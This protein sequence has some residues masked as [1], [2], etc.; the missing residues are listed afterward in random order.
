[1]A[2]ILVLGAGPAGISAALYARR[3]GADVLVIHRGKNTGALGRAEVIQNYYGLEC[4]VSGAELERRGIA[5]AVAL[6]VSVVEDELLALEYSDDFH[7]FRAVSPKQV[8]E[9]DSIVIAAGATRKAP[10]IPGLRELEGHGVSYCAVCDAFLYRGK[11]AAVLGSGEYAIHEM[12]ALLPHASEVLLFTQGESAPSSLPAKVTVHDSPVVALEGVD[13]LTGAVLESGEH[14]AIDGLFVAM[15]TASSSEL[16]RKLGVMLDG[17]NIKVGTHMETNVPGVFAAGD[18]TGG[19]LQIAKA[20][21][22]GAEAGLAAVKFLRDRM[23]S[24]KK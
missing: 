17:Q 14:I 16:A 11:V 12:E 15:G 24:G 23:Q 22:Q 19:L 5:G 21:Y 6:G 3:G 7:G 9:A 4:A 8:Y 20:V 18:C 10:K 1:M 2:R 13:R